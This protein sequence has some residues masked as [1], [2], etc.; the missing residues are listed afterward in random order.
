MNKAPD[1]GQPFGG[2]Q[3]AAYL[4]AQ[5]VI[6]RLNAVVPGSGARSFGCLTRR[7]APSACTWSAG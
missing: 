2:A 4:G 6:H 5:S 3:V 7:P 1:N